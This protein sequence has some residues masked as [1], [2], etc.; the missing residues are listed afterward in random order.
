[1]IGDGPVRCAVVGGELYCD[2][3]GLLKTQTKFTAGQAAK[4]ARKGKTTILRDI[5][6]GKLSADRDDNGNWQ[7]DLS[8]L[9]RVYPDV[10][11]DGTETGPEVH[12]GPPALTQELAEARVRIAE[13]SGKLDGSEETKALLQDQ[14]ENWQQQA[15]RLA[16]TDE[17]KR[18]ADAVI[19]ES[20]LA[21]TKALRKADARAER[22]ERIAEEMMNRGFFARLFKGSKS[23]A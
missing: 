9:V 11:V 18:E 14:L 15:K 13:L 3:G 23:I 2:I 10:K 5:D 16:L 17:R 7:I 4:R 19:Q 21:V 1:M 20:L 22:A 8:E 12:H 6:S